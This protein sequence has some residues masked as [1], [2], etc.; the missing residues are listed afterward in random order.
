MSNNISLEKW[1][2]IIKNSEKDFDV[3]DYQFM[4]DEHFHEYINSIDNR[5][6]S[7]IKFLLRRFLIVENM[8]LG[9]DAH[10]EK[11]I[12]GLDDEEIDKYI[13][14]YVFIKKLIFSKPWISIEW[15]FDLL[16]NHPDMAINVLRAYSIAHAQFLPDGRAMGLFDAISIIEAKYMNHRLPVQNILEDISPR[17]FEL[18]TAYL[19]KK[20]EYQIFITQRT[21]DGGYD[22]LAKKDNSREQEKIYIEC[23]RYIKKNVGVPLIRNLLGILSREIATKCVLVTTSYF[24]IDATKE[25]FKSKRLELINIDSFDM[26]MRRNVNY[27]WTK[28]VNSYIEEIKKEIKI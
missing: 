3:I 12:F 1:L 28:N 9:S 11:W 5:S 20:K 17:D 16:P 25:A 7:E 10:L 14:N 13:K 4:T 8:S 19:Y 2:K 24:T 23:K 26:E 27:N 18:L 22:I 21:R 6:D 15:I